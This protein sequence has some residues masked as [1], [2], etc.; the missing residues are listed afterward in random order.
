MLDCRTGWKL[1]AA[2][3]VQQIFTSGSFYLSALSEF[4]PSDIPV[5]FY[6]N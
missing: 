1:E 4:L 2:P 5:N 6:K 3:P